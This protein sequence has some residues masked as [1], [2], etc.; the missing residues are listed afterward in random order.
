MLKIGIS[1][2]PRK[3]AYPRYGE[4]VRE[5]AERLGFAGVEVVHLWD[6]PEAAAAIDGVVFTGGGDVA[7]E[8]YGKPHETARCRGIDPQRDAHEFRLCEIARSR[9]LPMLA[10]CR[11]AQLLNAAFGGDLIADIGAEETHGK[12]PDGRD[13]RHAVQA[14]SGSLVAHLAGGLR[15]DVN[16][17]HHQAVGTPAA[18]FAVTARADDGTVEA[19]EWAEPDGKPFLLA[20]QWHPERMDQSEPLAGPIFEAFLRASAAGSE[21]NLVRHARH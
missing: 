13:S 2:A 1:Y 14:L 15:G 8:R 21:Q 17:S 5:A 4:C 18:P 16:S 19:Y 6:D 10:I 7:P 12:R 11:G 9:A 3:Q 20:V